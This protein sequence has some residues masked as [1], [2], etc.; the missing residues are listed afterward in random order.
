MDPLQN[1]TT[2]AGALD[3]T[4]DAAYRAV[5]RLD[6]MLRDW[7]GAPSLLLRL[8]E[9][10]TRVHG[11][12][13]N[14]VHEQDNVGSPSSQA[15]SSDLEF[16]RSTLRR[17][18]EGVLEGAQGREEG[19]ARHGGGSPVSRVVWVQRSDVAEVQGALDE[20]Y[21]RLLVRLMALNV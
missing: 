4:V 13:V 21:Q 16:T 15:L 6:G 14:V 18:E 11:L 19:D 17:L 1:P 12:L 10:T 9:S 2:G 7:P 20:C 8:Q 5:M 3:A